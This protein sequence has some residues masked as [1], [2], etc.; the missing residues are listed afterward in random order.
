MSVTNAL[1]RRK[2]SVVRIYMTEGKGK[3]TV[4]TKEY[5]EYFP[6]AE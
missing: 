4:N 6:Q 5:T 2:A 3:I 1:G